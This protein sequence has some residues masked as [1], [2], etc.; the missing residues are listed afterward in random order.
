MRKYRI[1]LLGLA[2]LAAIGLAGCH[3]RKNESMK[4]SETESETAVIDFPSSYQKDY[5]N[6]LRADARIIVPDEVKGR[7]LQGA[8]VKL[9]KPDVDAVKL[10]TEEYLGTTLQEFLSIEQKD[11]Q[12]I[13]LYI[14]QY[15]DPQDGVF[16]NIFGRSKQLIIF[17]AGNEL[18][19]YRIPFGG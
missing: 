3:F 7:R 6:Q 2:L 9:I 15:A 19:P 13:T 1:V 4:N 17:P 14:R 5:D 16:S 8:K 11:Y 10:K 18:C 12:R